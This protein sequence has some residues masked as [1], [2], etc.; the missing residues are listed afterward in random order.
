M[1]TE[2]KPYI[3]RGK[4]GSRQTH[5]QCYPQVSGISLKS[6]NLLTRTL[7]FSLSKKMRKNNDSTLREEN[8]GLKAIRKTIRTLSSNPG[9]YRML[10]SQG[11]VLYVGK[12]KNLIRRVTSYAQV[13]K[14]PARLQRMVSET[15]TMEIVT[16][17]TETEALLLEANL[18]QRLKPKYNIVFRDNK[19]MAYILLTQEEWPALIKHRGPRQKDGQ[20]F[21]PFP[22]ATDVEKTLSS[23]YRAFLLRSCSDHFFKTRQ[24]PCLQYDMKRCSAPCVHRITPEAYKKL[25]EETKQFLSGGSTEI[26]QNLAKEMINLSALQ[27]YEQAAVIRDRIRALTHLQSHQTVFL[28]NLQDADVIAI[29]KNTGATA[30]QMFFVRGGGTYGTKTFFPP[31]GH[32]KDISSSAL[33]ESFLSQFYQEI[34]PPPLILV[35]EKPQEHKI[36]EEALSSLAG[37]PVR[38]ELP[39]QGPRADLLYQV[40]QNAQEALLRHLAQLESEEKLLRRVQELFQLSKFPERIEI[41]DNSHLQGKNAY[42]VM[43]VATPEGFFKKGYRKFTISSKITPGDDYGMMREVFSRRFERKEKTELIL[44]DLI[45]VD[46]GPGQLSVVKST[47]NSYNLSQIP[48]VAI[49]KGAD[50]HSGQETLYQWD[51]PPIKLKSDDPLLYYFQRLRDEAHRFAIT[52]H[53][54]KNLKSIHFS[55]LEKIPNIGKKRKAALLRHF[56]SFDAIKKAGVTDLC[57]VPSITRKIA[58]TIYEHFQNHD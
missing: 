36:L 13:E 1:Q 24:R 56:G 53:R 31:L 30:L 57:A 19:S 26:Q 49:A 41:Y 29:A 5:A 18:I 39:R 8:E 34:P 54:K 55:R 9:V 47:L 20:Y 35:N 51:C 32:S 50:R 33:L 42:G 37:H 7:F 4:R 6:I 46:G 28:N 43:V 12:A 16:T 38:I 21:G 10:G 17:H 48:V 25:V 27:A 14:L 40:S 22:S 23:L 52:T 2:K 3:S 58:E 15:R 45:L 11:E 44:P